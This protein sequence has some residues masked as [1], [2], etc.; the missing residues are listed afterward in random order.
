MNGPIRFALLVTLLLAPGVA[1]AGS[2]PVDCKDKASGF[3]LS[4]NHFSKRAA[5]DYA[6]VPGYVAMSRHAQEVI[7]FKKAKRVGR[8]IHRIFRGCTA[9]Y[10]GTRRSELKKYA[11]IYDTEGQVVALAKCQ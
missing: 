9:V 10:S 6:P 4:L 8:L 11:V 3:S 7:P 5:N 1:F 2:W